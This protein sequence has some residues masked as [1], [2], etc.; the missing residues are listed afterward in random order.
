[1]LALLDEGRVVDDQ[2]AFGAKH[3]ADTPP[4]VFLNQ[5]VLPVALVDELLERLD[6]V[7]LRLI[8]RG[9]PTGLRLD[10]FAITVEQEPA[11]IRRAPMFPLTASDAGGHVFDERL[12]L[13]LQFVKLPCIHARK[14]DAKTDLAQD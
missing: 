1:V 11:E 8:N 2:H 13:V 5:R 12:H 10:T 14:H 3:V 4:H 9:E 6:V 7:L